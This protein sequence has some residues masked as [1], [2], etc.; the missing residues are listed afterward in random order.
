MLAASNRTAVGPKLHTSILNQHKNSTASNTAIIQLVNGQEKHVSYNEFT[1]ES[2]RLTTALWNSGV[3]RSKGEHV[4]LLMLGSCEAIEVVMACSILGCVAVHVPSYFHPTEIVTW[5]NKV[6]AKV[7]FVDASYEENVRQIIP[8]LQTVTQV[9]FMRWSEE[10]LSGSDQKL[11]GYTEFK[12][13][14]APSNTKLPTGVQYTV[15]DTD[16]IFML[17]TTGTTSKPKGVVLCHKNILSVIRNSYEIHSSSDVCFVTGMYYSNLLLAMLAMYY[18]GKVIFPDFTSSESVMKQWQNNLHRTT[19]SLL[20]GLNLR[21]IVDNEQELRFIFKQGTN[22]KSLY[23]GGLITPP[24]LLQKIMDIIPGVQLFN[25]YGMTETAGPCVVTRSGDYV[26]NPSTDLEWKRLE[27]VGRPSQ[28]TEILVVDENGVE[29]GVG[30][31]G[32]VLLQSDTVMNGYFQDDYH[33]NNIVRDGWLHTGDIGYIDSD[34]YL[35]IIGRKNDVICLPFAD[36]VYPNVIE[37]AIL[38]HPDILSACCFGVPRKDGIGEDIKVAVIR[39]SS[40]TITE[41]QIIEHSKHKL[42]DFMVPHF[43]Q[44]CDSFPISNNKVQ[45]SELKRQHRIHDT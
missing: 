38:S 5:M 14:H 7:L 43:I 28:S 42:T 1:Q 18:G 13:I 15:Y 26:P 3:I 2:Y 23:F 25:G 8:Q 40:S 29:V 41:Q 9:I 22:F 31:E 16:P 39:S 24:Y 30:V 10:E 21:Y 44:F 45:K 27:S 17:L 11:L 35:Y 4:G 6:S 36:K 32:E 19:F 37:A 20:F 34:G 33:T 12:S